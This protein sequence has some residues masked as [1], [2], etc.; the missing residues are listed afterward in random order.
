[1][2]TTMAAFPIAILLIAGIFASSFGRVAQFTELAMSLHGGPPVVIGQPAPL[3]VR[4]DVQ[5]GAVAYTPPPQPRPI[6]VV[7]VRPSDQGKVPVNNN[8]GPLPGGMANQAPRPQDVAKT[9]PQAAARN[10]VPQNSAPPPMPMLNLSTEAA[11]MWKAKPDPPSET[12]RISS[13]LAML[14]PRSCTAATCCFRR[15][16]AGLWWLPVGPV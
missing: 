2:R 13:D 7:D 5:P 8:A 3:P 6:P 16:Q 4:R 12:I 15:C 11:S 14:L 9:P 1:M 10:S